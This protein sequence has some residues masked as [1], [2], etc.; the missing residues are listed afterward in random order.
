MPNDSELPDSATAFPHYFVGDAA[1][2]LKNN[3]M[4]P[5]PGRLLDDRKRIFN[6]RLSRA[7][8]IIE[9]SFGILESR[10][11]ILKTTLNC[12]PE[13]AEKIT[14]AS[15][16]LHNFTMKNSREIYC[17]RNYVDYENETGN[18]V[19]GEWRVNHNQPLISIRMGSNNATR[20][21][22]NLRDILL[23]YFLNEGAVDFQ[24]DRHY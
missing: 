9:N 11:R 13:N 7:R 4:R 6:Y 8:R 14:L 5:F 24:F 21:A 19:P 2:P 3:L 16:A 1:F 10:W 20:T 18:I 23:N 17:P 12:S 22:F 15:L